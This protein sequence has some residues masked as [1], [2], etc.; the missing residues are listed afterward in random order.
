MKA[1]VL[2]G[3]LPGQTDLELVQGILAEELDAS[4]WEVETIHLSERNIKACTG[5]FRCWTTTPGICSGVKGDEA[6]LIT[7]KVI[8]SQLLVFL[9]PLTYGGY[10]SEIKKIYGRLVGLLQPG[11]EIID[12]EVHHLKRYEAYPS[13]LGIGMTSELDE[14]EATVFKNLVDR[15]SKNFYPPLFHAGVLV[16]SDEN[17]REKLSDMVKEVTK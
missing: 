16:Y 14:E 13:F 1:L 4:G 2:D 9:T 7:R 15:N 3:R 6:E 11:T 12:G 5:C 17:M 8:N 10:S